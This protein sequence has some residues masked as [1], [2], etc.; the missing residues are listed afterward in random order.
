MFPQRHVS[1]D[2]YFD[3][4]FQDHCDSSGTSTFFFS[5]YCMNTYIGAIQQSPIAD[6]TKAIYLR[7]LMTVARLTNKP[8]YSFIF[9]PNKTYRAMLDHYPN[10]KTRRT[11]IIAIKSIF[12]HLPD[13]AHEH[14]KVVD[15]WHELYLGLHSKMMDDLMQ[16]DLS[17]RER[18][19]WVH[20]RDVLAMERHLRDTEYASFSHVLL[21]M[22]TLIE[23]SRQD[24][25]SLRLLNAH[26]PDITSGNYMV[27]HLNG[28]PVDMVLNEY[29]T[30]KSYGR[31]TRT[32]PRELSEIIFESLRQSP[33]HYLFARM[34][35]SAYDKKA[36]VRRV[37]DELAR[38]FGRRF[39]IGML[40]HAFISEGIDFNEKR[41]G[42]LF[43]IARNM[44]H[45]ISQQQQYRRMPG[46]SV[47]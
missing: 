3:P 16:G 2:G 30:A 29:K 41:P 36:F 15:R 38:L 8:D 4:F 7:N 17:E 45:S 11:V 42:E 6:T 24:Y 32:L 23:P 43:D 9:Q 25:N 18:E 14:K 13:L 28:E 46:Q 40:R 39:T 31:Y 1:G 35:G 47:K 34:D 10:F 27:I 19:N 22:Y 44:H 20:W 21:A 33:R 26:P 37:N 12:K 5:P